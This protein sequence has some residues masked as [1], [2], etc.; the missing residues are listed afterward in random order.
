MPAMRRLTLVEYQ[1]Q[2][3][4]QLSRAERDTL[5]EVAPS[6]AVAPSFGKNIDDADAGYDLT[7]SSW[8]G[9]IQLGTLAIDVRPKLA[10][11]RVLF[12]LSYALD[13]WR[14]QDAPFEFGEA[15]SL[16]DAVIISFIGC[17]QRALQRGT[18]QGYRSEDTMLPTIRGRLRFEAQVREQFG[19]VLP[20]AVRLDEFTED[21]E[22]NRL[23]KA[24][25]ARLRRLPFLSGAAARSLVRLE[26]P[27]G[28]VRAVTYDARRLPAVAY[29]RLNAHYR[30]AVELAKLILRAASFELGHGPVPASAFLVDMNQVFE[31]FVVVALRQA[32]GLSEHTFPQ[33]AAGKRIALDQVGAIHLRPDLSWWDG[34]TCTFVGDVKYKR[35]QT[36]DGEHA[37][38]YQLLAYTI[39]TGVPG[40]LL[41]Y[42]AP[43]DGAPAP[44]SHR[45]LPITHGDSPARAGRAEKEKEKE[46][47]K[48]LRVVA[49]DL[50]RS[51]KALLKTI[52]G[53]AREIR[54]LR[55]E[56]LHGAVA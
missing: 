34:A 38:L 32:L 16:V 23:I 36:A 43:E 5:R 45:V 11:E 20:A 24:A 25:I 7:P 42:A 37:D 14:W 26:T 27:V 40:G 49:L 18:L 6:V 47:E 51:P 15:G 29:T 17:V 12:L 4:V 35:L 31:D 54:Q 48:I 33:G 53:I 28:R 19:L 46:K 21:I 52:A 8:V 30:P 50:S 2:T 9:A 3:G 39:A 22:E 13:P 10:P 55:R 1:T 44:V 41:I 56:A